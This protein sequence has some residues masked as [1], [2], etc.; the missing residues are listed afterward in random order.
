[1]VASIGMC[2]KKAFKV[3]M[4]KCTNFTAFSYL[5][6]DLS[7][8]KSQLHLIVVNHP[9]PTVKNKA[10]LLYLFDGIH[11]LVEQLSIYPGKLVLTTGGLHLP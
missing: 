5:D 7:I 4:L 9:P 11:Y 1:M 2:L 3:K 8:S 6:L 10:T